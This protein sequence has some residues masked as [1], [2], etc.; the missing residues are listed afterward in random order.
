MSLSKQSI[1]DTHQ[2]NLAI[3]EL[4]GESQSLFQA[5]DNA[6]AI[7]RNFE[8]S[9]GENKAHFSFSYAVHKESVPNMHETNGNHEENVGP[10]CYVGYNSYLEWSLSWEED[11][12][13]NRFRL[14]LI[15][16]RQE[17]T[18]ADIEGDCQ[19]SRS[20]LV[21]QIEFKKPLIETD[22]STRL[23]FVEHLQK[24][25]KKF[26]EHLT[27]YRESIEKMNFNEKIPF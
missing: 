23:R 11:E 2:L 13:S 15:S 26:T 19:E 3:K 17:F 8:K 10:W 9:M 12:K 5:M 4:V 16:H 21:N 27:R 6:S 25:V 20:P 18:V 7:I 14:F 24:F 22:L 1:L